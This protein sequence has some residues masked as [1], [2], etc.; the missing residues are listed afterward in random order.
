MKKMFSLSILLCCVAVCFATTANLNGEW[1]GTLKTDDGSE[2]PLLYNFKVDGDKLTG[3]VKGPHGDLPIIDGEVH[4]ANFDF[5]VDLNKMHLLHSG[6]FCADSVSLDI[7]TGDN[8]AH[9]TLI[10]ADK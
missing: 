2:Y 7:E 8:K 9:T 3:T 6:K 10:R 5:D 1:S 4:G